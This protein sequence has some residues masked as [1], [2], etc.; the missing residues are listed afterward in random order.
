MSI[1]AKQALEETLDARKQTV[2]TYRK[3]LDKVLERIVKAA[4]ECKT[5]VT[6]TFSYNLYDD[7]QYDTL[8]SVSTHLKSL[9]YDVSLQLLNLT[10]NFQEQSYYRLHVDWS[11]AKW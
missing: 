8:K 11:N 10:I 1:T 5:D 6:T 7:N 4:R 9:G 3:S 2:V